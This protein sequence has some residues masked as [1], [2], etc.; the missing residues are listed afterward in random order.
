MSLNAVK[1]IHLFNKKAGFLNAPM[2]GFKESAYQIEEA[3]E[4]YEAVIG[5]G[6]KEFSREIME[7]VKFQWSA[8]KLPPLS[9]IS[10]LD[11]AVDGI[12]FNFGKIFKM[13]LTP[14][15]AMKALEVVMRYNMTKLTAGTDSEGKQ[16]KPE[17]FVGP[18]EELQKILDKRGQK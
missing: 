16:L 12:I 11:K 1:Q 7:E 6:A 13:R 15:E 5:M 17:G 14:Q 4:G 10:E 2:D 18:E 9:E 8:G 3:L